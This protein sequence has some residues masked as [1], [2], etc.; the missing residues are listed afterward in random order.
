MEKKFFVL[1]FVGI[2]LMHLVSSFSVG[3]FFSELKQNPSEYYLLCD[4]TNTEIISSAKSFADYFGIEFS[5]EMIQNKSPLAILIPP[6]FMYYFYF[7]E[8][9]I[10][11]VESKKTS[12]VNLLSIYFSNSSES[13]VLDEMSFIFNYLKNNQDENESY[14]LFSNSGIIDFEKFSCEGFVSTSVYEKNIFGSFE[15]VCVDE[16]T[17]LKMEC[18]SELKFNSVECESGCVDGKCSSSKESVFSLIKKWSAGKR[19][20]FKSIFDLFKLNFFLISKNEN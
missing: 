15:D 14:L 5:N 1:L 9:E 4:S 12:D 11:Y 19:L 8:N 18:D 3:E 10:S 17:L 6:S 16:K 20:S 13:S 7:Y 2:F